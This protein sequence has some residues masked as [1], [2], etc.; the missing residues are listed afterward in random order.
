MARASLPG[1]TLLAQLNIQLMPKYPPQNISCSGI[2]ILPPSASAV[3]SR[4]VSAR[5]SG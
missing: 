1:Q 5:V 3:K 4:S 2:S